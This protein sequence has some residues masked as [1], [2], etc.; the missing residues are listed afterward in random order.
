[1]TTRDCTNVQ[2]DAARAS[3]DDDVLAEKFGIQVLAEPFPPAA[4][5]E[6]LGDG[7]DDQQPGQDDHRDGRQHLADLEPN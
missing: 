5:F 2:T 6:D 4:S 1:M 7:D 3:G